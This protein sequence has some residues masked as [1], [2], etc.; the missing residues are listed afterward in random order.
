M[1]GYRFVGDCRF[2]IG[3]LSTSEA[4]MVGSS[5]FVAA[6]HLTRDLSHED[7]EETS[8]GSW[9][10]ELRA[11]RGFS[12]GALRGRV[13]TL[14]LAKSRIINV[15]LACRTNK[16]EADTEYADSLASVRRRSPGS[17]PRIQ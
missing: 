14:Q 8:R 16:P 1:G 7:H 5:E 11:L 4:A 2:V 10:R 3:G 9:L 13:R 6:E 12:L 15:P 17:G